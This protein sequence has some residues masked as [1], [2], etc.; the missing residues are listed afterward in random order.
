MEKVNITLAFDQEKLNA[1]EF[2]LKKKKTTA[3]RRLEE[4]LPSSTSRPCPRRCGSTWTA[5][6]LPRPGRAV[7]P[8]P[9]HPR[10]RWS[11][12]PSKEGGRSWTVGIS[13]SGWTRGG[14]PPCPGIWTADCGGSAGP[15]SE[16]AHQPASQRGVRSDQPGDPGGDLRQKSR[17]SRPPKNSRRSPCPGAWA[18]R[19]LPAG[20]ALGRLER[21]Q[22]PAG[23]SSQG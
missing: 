7:R 11:P 23:I 21:G 5:A 14:T 17:K 20:A 18:G 9:T 15:L 2:Y 6:P 13:A 19:I 22:H 12:R 1:L 3:Q 16:G 8:R 10:G 4:S